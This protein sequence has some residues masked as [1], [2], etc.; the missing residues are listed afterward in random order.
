MSDNIERTPLANFEY[1]A[2]TGEYLRSLP[3][4]ERLAHLLREDP[5]GCRCGICAGDPERYA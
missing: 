3:L 2:K 5:D 4:K 1:R